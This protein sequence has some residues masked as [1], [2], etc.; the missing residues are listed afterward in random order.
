MIKGLREILWQTLEA[1]GT[2]SAATRIHQLGDA[3]VDNSLAM[4][5]STFITA[6]FGM[7]TSLS[8]FDLVAQVLLSPTCVPSVI[9]DQQRRFTCSLLRHIRDHSSAPC[10]SKPRAWG[11][12]ELWSHRGNGGS[13][14]RAPT[15]VQRS[16]PRLFQAT[17]SLSLDPP[18][19]WRW[20][21]LH[22]HTAVATDLA[23]GCLH[24]ATFR[25]E[26]LSYTPIM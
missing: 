23:N 18:R 5:S 22:Q 15:C 9:Q 24:L 8:A 6:R 11:R 12:Q 2:W 25:R 3:S 1:G 26:N 14:A 10:C 7:R 4:A 20:R 21:G 19:L 13:R 17:P 16:Y